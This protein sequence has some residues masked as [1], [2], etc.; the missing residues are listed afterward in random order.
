MLWID[1]CLV[2]SRLDGMVRVGEL[3]MLST[4]RFIAATL[5]AA[6]AVASPAFAGAETPSAFELCDGH[7]AP[8]EISDGITGPA[9]VKLAPMGVDDAPPALTFGSDGVARCDEALASPL[10]QPAYWARRVNLRQARALHLLGEGKAD[11]ALAE[12]QRAEADVKTPDDPFYRRSLG[13]AISL[14]RAFA[15]RM[16]GEKEAGELMAVRVYEARPYSREV[17]ATARRAMGG[18]PYRPRVLQVAEGMARLDPRTIDD[19]FRNAFAEGRFGDVVSLFS[20]LSPPIVDRPT[21]M[22]ERQLA[23][24]NADNAGLSEQYWAERT[25]YYAFALSMLGRT[26][27]ARAALKAERARLDAALEA[28]RYS[29]EPNSGFLLFAMQKAVDEGHYSVDHWSTMIDRREDIL[30]GGK[31]N[32]GMPY[33]GRAMVEVY[34]ASWARLPADQKVP[35]S[36]PVERWTKSAIESKDDV[37]HILQDLLK[38]VPPEEEAGD[39]PPNTPAKLKNPSNLY[40]EL[41]AEGYQVVRTPGQE[42]VVVRFRGRLTTRAIVEEMTL[43]HVAELALS[44]GKPAFVIVGR[45]DYSYDTGMAAYHTAMDAEQDGYSTELSV[46]LVDPAALPARFAAAPWRVIDAK[47]VESRLL[48]VLAP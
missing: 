18:A 10:L 19:I 13:L 29:Q 48:P 9:P 3:Q 23:R 5:V 24:L 28:A 33:K 42:A 37:P 17:A 40:D 12:L 15:L 38:N 16:K 7:S 1:R 27:E 47:D 8:T 25:G 30:A 31:L 4:F 44:E 35:G 34:Q 6:A 2:G 11:E 20:Q 46:I 36:S 26:G 32:P 45:R 22:E 14:T 21:Y 41:S 39:L 43:L